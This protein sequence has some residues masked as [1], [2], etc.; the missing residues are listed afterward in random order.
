M[1]SL[2]FVL[3]PLLNSCNTADSTD[4]LHLVWED[5]FNGSKPDTLKWN[6]LLREHSKSCWFDWDMQKFVPSETINR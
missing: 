3:S 5:N 6:A 1:F 4:N 2:L